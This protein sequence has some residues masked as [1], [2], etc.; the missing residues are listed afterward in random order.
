[1]RFFPGGDREEIRRTIAVLSIPL[2]AAEAVNF[3]AQLIVVAILGHMGGN[4]IYLRSV[5]QPVGLLMLALTVGFSVTNQVATAIN[6][7]AGR[8]REVMAHAASLARIWFVCATAVCAVLVLVAPWLADLVGVS[9]QT[10]HAAVSFLRWTCVSGLLTIGPEL[11]ASSLRG[12]GHAR[13]ATV[14]VLC[15]AVVQIGTVAG[16]G[17]GAGLG[18]T[19]VPIAQAA[20]GLVG[21]AA[22]LVMLRR[23]VLWHPPAVR[24]WQRE[25]LTG[26]RRIGLPVATSLLV[27]AGYN[28]AVL[29]ILG[30][31]GHEVVAGY[32]AASA[33]QN[34]VLLPGTVIGTAT[35]III[36]QQ[37]GANEWH[38]MTDAARRGLEISGGV[39][40][41]IAVAVWAFAHPVAQLLSDDAQVATSAES[42]LAIVAFSFFFQGPVLTALTVME[43]T[44]G[45]FRAIVLNAVYFGLIV[46]VGLLLVKPLGGAHGFYK[47]VAWCN[48]IGISVP[49]LAVRYVRRMSAAAPAPEHTASG[50]RTPD[51]HPA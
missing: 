21:T 27:I 39:Y 18:A 15:T 5:Y 19:A 50:D 30:K 36:N 17:I 43:Q 47:V 9:A 44:G 11:C 1:V 40:V 22:G 24:S 25:A 2:F 13:R 23:T 38:R 35:A 20:A 6:K 37:L 42:Y 4:A 12:Y 28:V 34:L 49:F 51:G 32:S 10:H 41:I 48:V 33:L 29:G 16:L 7:G 46:V 8:P 14:L 26:L 45:G 3:L 31:Y